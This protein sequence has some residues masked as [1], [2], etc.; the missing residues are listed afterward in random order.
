MAVQNR[1]AKFLQVFKPGEIIFV[2]VEKVENDRK[3]ERTLMDKKKK[4][5]QQEINHK[6]EIQGVHKHNHKVVKLC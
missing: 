6:M 3:R 1:F 5:R 2:A 4:E